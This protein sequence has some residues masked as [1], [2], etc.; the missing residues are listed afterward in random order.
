MLFF[1]SIV[2]NF[3]FY[4]ITAVM[5]IVLLPVFLLPRKM[6]WP[7]VPLWARVNLWLLRWIVGLKIEVRGRENL[8]EGGYI[9]AS[10]HQSAWETF[11]L[12]P[13]FPDPTYILKRELR[14]I[15]LFGWYT[16]KMKQI[17]VDRG[18]RAAALAK[19]SEHALEAVKEGRQIL[20]FP[21]GTRTPSGAEPK[22]KYGVAHL[23]KSIGCPVIP[24]ALNSGLFWPRRGFWRY[25]G[26]VTLEFLPPIEPGLQMEAFHKTLLRKVEEASDR[27]IEEAAQKYPYLPRL[28][29]VEERWSARGKS[30]IRADRRKG[31]S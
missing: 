16:A 10:K 17:P 4:F 11:A 28:D 31:A 26:T 22:Y 5:M 30:L 18:K 23:Y 29:L 24:V 14:Y 25:P 9:V 12:I 19:M 8:P 2:F 6:G 27:L 7:I 1:R 3:L 13:E 21:E 15:P 20:I